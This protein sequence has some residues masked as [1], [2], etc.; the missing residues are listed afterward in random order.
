VSKPVYDEKDESAIMNTFRTHYLS[1][2]DKTEEFE[3]NFSRA[4][5]VKHSVAVNS[6]SSAN[7][8]SLSV[9]SCE[10]VSK[11]LGRGDEVITPALTWA[12]T[13]FPIIQVG[14]TPVFVDVDPKT[15]CLD[16]EEV[17]K[18]V[19]PRT[20][21]IM[22]VHFLGH[23][24]DMDAI[25]EVATKHGLF[26]I[27]DCCEALGSKFKGQ[28]VGTF[29]DMSTF[30]FFETHHVST[31]EGG[32]ICTNRSLYSSLARSFRAFGRACVCPTCRLHMQPPKPCPIRYKVALPQLEGYDKR[33]VFTR[34]GYSLKMTE[35]QASLGVTQLK[36]LGS[37][38]ETREAN[39]KFYAE[40][41]TRYSDVLQIPSAAKGITHSW[42]AYPIIVKQGEA[43]TRK[44]IVDYLESRG[45][46]TRP[47]MTGDISVQ[48]CLRN[49]K[50]RR[51]GH[52][53]V[54]KYI[55]NNGFII[56]CHPMIGEEQR[57]YVA[58]SLSR[59][60]ESHSR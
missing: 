20:K 11:G 14:A 31:G 24:A 48:P 26:V 38:L 47:M 21:A 44:Q 32:M 13:C 15:Y 4:I 2:H 8:V 40:K 22:L 1:M 23:P 30:S 37:F 3:D 28:H 46:E 54:T 16:P 5:G 58:D 9:L 49:V 18:A 12:T 19:T 10:D 34:I 45:I 52:L 35:L 29:G 55:Q 36:K 7:L 50:F 60:L 41:L 53:P 57:I 27:E 6:G 51:V 59:F 33:Y 43:F 42:F 25:S 39:A 56:G 17:E